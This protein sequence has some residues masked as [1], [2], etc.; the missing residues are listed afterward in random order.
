MNEL[1]VEDMGMKLLKR[2]ML[3][4]TLRIYFSLY[5]NNVLCVYPH[6]LPYF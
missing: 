6:I 4:S 5:F 2:A 1:E 3:C